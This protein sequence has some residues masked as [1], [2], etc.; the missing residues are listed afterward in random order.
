MLDGE[1]VLFFW[2]RDEEWHTLGDRITL[3]QP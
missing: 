2:S 1:Y 3:V